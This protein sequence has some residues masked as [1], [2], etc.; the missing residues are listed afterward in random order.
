MNSKVSELKQLIDH[1]L[2]RS[3]PD[4]IAL[5]ETWLTNNSPIPSIPGYELVQKCREH[6][7]GGGVA[8][9]ISNCI[10]FKVLNDIKYEAPDIE[11][12]FVE[13]KLHTR[14]VIIGNCYRPP[15][16]DSGQFIKSHKAL[17]QT[18]HNQNKSVIIGM[19]HNLDLL[20]AGHHSKT[21][22]FLETNLNANM[23]PTIIR[24]TR[25]SKTTATL[26]DNI[27]V[28][29][30]MHSSCKS[31][32]LID[33]ISDHLPCL[34]SVSGIKHK[35]KDPIKIQS[36]DLKHIDWLKHALS[37]TDWE[38][39]YMGKNI[40]ENCTKFSTTLSNMV[41]HFIPIK[42]KTIPYGK[43]RKEAWITPGILKS[44]KKEKQLYREMMGKTSLPVETRL[45][46]QTKYKRYKAQ[47]QKIKRRAKQ[48]YYRT[49]CIDFKC[50]TKKLWATMNSAVNRLSD[51]SSVIKALTVDGKK[52]DN[53]TAVANH[54]GNY[55]ASVGANYAKKIPTPKKPVNEYIDKISETVNSMYFPPTDQNEIK[56][57][58]SKLPNKGSSGYD[59]ICNKLLKHIKDEISKPLCELFYASLEQG[60]FP[61]N[62]KLSEVI[63][64]HKGKSRDLPE[65]YR[66]I[67]LLI[68]I[69]KV[70]EKLVYKRVYNFLDSNGSLYTSQ[71]GFRSN[72]LTDNAVTELLGEVLKNLE[73]KKYTLAI[74]L[75]L[76][77]AFDTLEHEVVIKKLAR[78]GI[79][80]TC[81]EWFKSYLTNR[82]MRLKCRTSLSPEEVKSKT[83][84][85]NY[86]TP[87]GSCLG[88]LVF[89]VFC[90]DL[91]LHL[92]HT[93]CI[94]F[95]DDTTIYTGSKN[96]NYL[97]Y[98][99]E[100][101]L[102]TLQ[103]WF[104]ANKLTL[105][106]EK[107][108]RMLFSPNQN[109]HNDKNIKVE[110]NSTILPMVQSVKFLGTWIDSTLNWK[111]HLEKL[112]L[113]ITSR[114]CL[115]KRGKR[116][117]NL[118]A[119]K[120]LYYA[121]IHSLIQY[122]IVLWGNMINKS[123]VEKLQK[124]QNISVRQ[125]DS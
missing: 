45:R 11:S 7:C 90:N 52:I 75:D 28:S 73:N 12:C 63:P 108:V 97:K 106:V 93:K 80:G 110:L 31:W 84:D 121:Q 15:N 32:I 61:S 72:H 67:S 47:L 119:L 69:S 29:L 46:V 112:S 102:C 76:S 81:L 101:D 33:S 123:Q 55:F 13:I 9:L 120:V 17:L 113:R 36:R 24:P 89:L 20:K 2:H 21:Q 56:R 57:V 4:I 78:Y 38:Y 122:G 82:S 85:V 92:E 42:S 41:D 107:T 34:L 8:L 37:M 49:Q 5:C 105:N 18:L 39:L 83:Y 58:I 51:K 14:Q 103:D 68:T 95:A 109:N 104:N 117:L 118:H 27:F 1:S 25:I 91:H 26:I 30:D 19:D 77:K 124:L 10:P 40:E 114:N 54:L 94:Q 23:Y 3:P 116:L 70:L 48:S 74:F 6:K 86:G 115:L 79:R 100:Q 64:L 65:N 53:P 99:I 60:I 71:Y 66:P 62:M 88:P 50:N 43:L 125:I 111:T 44:I 16:T 22:E 96:L 59:S 35:L 98:C 87:Q